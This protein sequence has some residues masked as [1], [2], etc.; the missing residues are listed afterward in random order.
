MA[1]PITPPQEVGQPAEA[2]FSTNM[3]LK[4]P[5]MGRLQFTFRGATSRDWGQ[6]L[7]DVD[8]FSHYMVEKG[9]KFDGETEMAPAPAPDPAAQIAMQ[10]GNNSLASELQAAAAQVP[11]AP[12]GKQW[13][14][15]NAAFVRILPQPED[16]ITIEFYGDDRKKPRNDFPALKANKWDVGRAIGLM[17][18]VT[19]HDVTKP[20]E[21]ALRC[22]VYYLEGKEYTGT[23]GQK[24]HY[25]DIYHVR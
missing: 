4:H 2:G 23:N 20:A 10:E 15:Y 22:T 17:K 6:V 1:T 3:Y 24:G 8:R 21:F 12:D 14:T 11:P 18:H 16:K 9:W 25:K 19:S 13:L 7:E 5:K